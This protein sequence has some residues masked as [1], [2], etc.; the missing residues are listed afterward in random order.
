MQVLVAGCAVSN[1]T[2]LLEYQGKYLLWSQWC[3]NKSSSNASGGSTGNNASVAKGGLLCNSDVTSTGTRFS[4][5]SPDSAAERYLPFTLHYTLLQEGLSVAVDA[6][7]YGNEARFAR[8]S[9]NPNAQVLTPRLL[10]LNVSCNNLM[11]LGLFSI[12]EERLFLNNNRELLIQYT[13]CHICHLSK[14]INTSV[15]ISRD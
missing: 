13:F 15:F 1:G 12:V 4:C 11:S 2:A 10:C 6:R 3:Q 7:T 14:A 5:A 9:C 8:R